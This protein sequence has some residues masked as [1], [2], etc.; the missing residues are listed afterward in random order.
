MFGKENGIKLLAKLKLV[1]IKK[2]TFAVNN[3]N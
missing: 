3:E 2:R 1:R